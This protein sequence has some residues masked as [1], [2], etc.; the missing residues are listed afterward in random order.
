MNKLSTIRNK[1][2][3]LGLK[4]KIMVSTRP[5]KKYVYI[6]PNGK[7]VHFGAQG[8][9]DYLDHKDKNRRKA[10]RSRH[11]KIITK[12]GKLAYKVYESP[13]FLSYY[14]LW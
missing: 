2:A 4:G 6:K 11:S 3:S 12:N 7:L 14:L 8:Y 9:Q 13:A 5:E 1:A 10:Y